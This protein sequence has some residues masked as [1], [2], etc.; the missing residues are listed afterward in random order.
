MR[1]FFLLFL[2][3]YHSLYCW[4]C[5]AKA[6]LLYW[7][8][9]KIVIF[10]MIYIVLYQCLNVFE[11]QTSIQDLKQYQNHLATKNIMQFVFPLSYFECKNANAFSIK[12][13]TCAWE[14]LRFK[15]ASIRFRPKYIF[16]LF[17]VYSELVRHF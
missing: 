6:K 3:P 11:F 14:I 1:G 5:V 13:I 2:Y 7:K 12:W 15:G 9:I 8:H 4:F 16:F 17:N 10:L